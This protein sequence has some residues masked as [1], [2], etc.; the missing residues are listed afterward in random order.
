M[1]DFRGEVV[2]VPVEIVPEAPVVERAPVRYPERLVDRHGVF[3]QDEFPVPAPQL[4]DPEVPGAGDPE[5]GALPE[6]SE[7]ITLI[8]AETYR[9]LGTDGRDAVVIFIGDGSPR[10]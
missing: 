2:K 9:W 8:L 6:F 10:P 5:A 4:E 3:T 7:S 1:T